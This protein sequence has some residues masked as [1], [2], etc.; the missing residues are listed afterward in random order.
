MLCRRVLGWTPR[1]REDTLVDT[2][3]S[4]LKLGLLKESKKS[5]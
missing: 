3:E 1:P 5:S 4:L 2:A